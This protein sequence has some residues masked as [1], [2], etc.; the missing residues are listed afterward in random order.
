[1]VP[2]IAY[3][4]TTGWIGAF[5]SIEAPGVD[6]GEGGISNFGQAGRSDR[7][8]RSSIMDDQGSDDEQVGR[9]FDALVRRLLKTPPQSRAE[10][11]EAARAKKGKVTRKRGERANAGKRGGAA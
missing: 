9:R 7:G 3:V 6:G 4:P 1:M 10:V 2:T 8:G 5:G 11:A